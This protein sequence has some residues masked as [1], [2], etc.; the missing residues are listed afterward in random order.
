MLRWSAAPAIALVSLVTVGSASA[1]P[2]NATV[3][4]KN[5]QTHRGQ[6]PWTRVDKG[7]FSLRK[8][9][10]D[11]LRVPVSDVVSVDF[12]G[13]AEPNV[14]LSGSQ[15]AVVLRNGTII[16]GQLI[17]M[18][19][20]SQNDQSTEYLVIIRDEQGQERRFPGPQVGRVYFSTAPTPTTGTP[21]QPTAGGGIVVPGNQRWVSTGLTVRAGETLTINTTGEIRI[22]S[23]Q[24]DVAGPAGSRS[25]RYASGAPMPR[26]LAGALIGRIGANGTPF[27]IGDQRSVR[28][29]EAG[30]L[31]LGINDDGVEDNSGEFRVEIQ[32]SGM[33]RR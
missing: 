22:S 4:L 7:E 24:N 16:K 5:G 11:E 13:T 33:R 21:N 1:Q 26:A 2:V 25:Q 29:P 6:N 3:V 31:F 17:E 8:S 23:D 10:H 30:V 12:G 18:A 14:S 19:H 15:Q 32:R 20:T 9:L 28:M 27:G